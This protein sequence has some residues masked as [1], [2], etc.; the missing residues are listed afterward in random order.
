LNN[1]KIKNNFPIITAIYLNKKQSSS[2]LNKNKN[3]N[4][5]VVQKYN[6]TNSKNKL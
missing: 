4:K 2:N 5:R 6:K 1:N 3:K